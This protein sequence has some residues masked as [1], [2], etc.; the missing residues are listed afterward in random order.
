MNQHEVDGLASGASV[1]EQVV[2]PGDARMHY[3]LEA[4]DLAFP[5]ASFEASTIRVAVPQSDVNHWAR[6]A[7]IGIYFELPAGGT[8]LHVAIEKDL[9][10][11]DGPPEERDPAAFPRDAGR[12]C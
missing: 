6:S 9:E 8:S 3:V 5:S 2:F 10:C 7:D 11:L 4:V 12:A 1:R